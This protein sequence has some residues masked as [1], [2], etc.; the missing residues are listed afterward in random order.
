MTGRH[1]MD[2]EPRT[3]HKALEF[4]KTALA[5]DRALFGGRANAYYHR[6][7]TFQDESNKTVSTC[8]TDN[9][10]EQIDSLTKAIATLNTNL[11]MPNRYSGPESR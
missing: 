10:Q 2:M 6:L 11:R 7:V 9:L 3:I 1:A 8:S 4:V 5:N